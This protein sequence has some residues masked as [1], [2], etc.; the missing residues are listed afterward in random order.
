MSDIAAD[1]VKIAD[2]SRRAD[3]TDIPLGEQC[4]EAAAEIERLRE[5]L[6]NIH[7]VA[8]QPGMY[9]SLRDEVREWSRAA[10]AGAGERSPPKPW[11]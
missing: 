7:A 1:L 10:L 6:R 4:R 9:P 3:G 11:G 8:C 5:A 2:A